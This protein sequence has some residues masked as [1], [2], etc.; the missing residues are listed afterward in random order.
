MVCMRLN[1][2]VGMSE[3]DTVEELTHLLRVT[4][5]VN[6]VGLSDCVTRNGNRL[7]WSLERKEALDSDSQ[8]AHQQKSASG[9]IALLCE[10]A[11][12]G[13]TSYPDCK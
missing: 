12:S 1:L 9:E 10:E 4:T 7:R 6:G 2:T 8:R 13:R 11:S 5:E 3:Q